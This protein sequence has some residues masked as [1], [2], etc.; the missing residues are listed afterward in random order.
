MLDTSAIIGW[1]ERTNSSLPALLEAGDSALYHPVTLGE[2]HAGIERAGTE[3]ELE[4]RTNTLQFTVQRLQAVAEDV[5]PAQQ[6]GFL[7]ARFSR[8]L[9]HNDYWIVASTVASGGLTLVTE[10]AELFDLV[11]S[12]VFAETLTRRA[13]V[14]PPCRLVESTPV[15]PHR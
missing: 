1:L 15:L 13:W 12:D 2:L 5:L 3:A 11:T 14:R 7:T 10:D 6:F 9:S 8:R 4:M